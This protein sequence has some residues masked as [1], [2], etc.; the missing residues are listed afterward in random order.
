[1]SAADNNPSPVI[2]IY[3]LGHR[4][5]QVPEAIMQ[6]KDEDFL[7]WVHLNLSTHRPVPLNAA[8]AERWKRLLTH[9]ETIIY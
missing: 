8:R 2:R 3:P 7:A 1:M 6:P 9:P 5:L 4:L